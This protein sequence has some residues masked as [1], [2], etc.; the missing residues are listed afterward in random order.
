MS[1]CP[2][3]VFHAKN[4][5]KQ[6]ENIIT[7]RSGYVLNRIVTVLYIRFPIKSIYA[8][9]FLIRRPQGHVKSIN[10]INPN[11]HNGERFRRE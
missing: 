10:E 2:Q 6:K 8:S 5:L 3:A 7:K 1:R 4:L 9:A 11:N